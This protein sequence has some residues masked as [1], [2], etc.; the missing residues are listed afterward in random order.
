MHLTTRL[1]QG[2]ALAAVV[3]GSAACSSSS[4][5]TSSGQPTTGAGAV[6]AI[7]KAYSTLFDLANPAVAPKLAVVQDGAALQATFTSAVKSQIAKTA[8]GARV[9]T[10]TPLTTTAC[11]NEALP[12]PCDGVKFYVLSTKG[13][14]LLP[15]NGFAVYMDGKWLVAKVTICGL[16]SLA[17]GGK[18]PAGC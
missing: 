6:A 2:V 4:G 3:V 12:A 8:G 14:T 18:A 11:S 13:K 16:L 7:T 1:I 10:V 17:A 15:D 9:V 5:P